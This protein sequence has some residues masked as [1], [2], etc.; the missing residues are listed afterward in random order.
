MIAAANDAGTGQ[1]LIGAG[2]T[3]A[4]AL[5]G[6]IGGAVLTSRAQSKRDEQERTFRQELERRS[7]EQRRIVLQSDRLR[8]AYTDV[9]VAARA[10]N[11]RAARLAWMF[12][13]PELRGKLDEEVETFMTELE[14]SLAALA[15][16]Q[17]TKPVLDLFEHVRTHY[18][19]YRY[20]VEDAVAKTKGAY[21]RLAEAIREVE[22][23]VP[24]LEQRMSDHLASL[25]SRS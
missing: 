11:A 1:L 25:D 10:L 17:G 22:K 9:L 12:D 20:G 2:I 3:L 18:I 4:A 6:G 13:R 24:V 19:D 16:E 7:D 14:R 23:N 15:L 8:V 5:F 21:G